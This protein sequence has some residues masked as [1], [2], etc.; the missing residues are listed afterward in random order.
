MEEEYPIPKCNVL[1]IV[2]IDEEK[3]PKQTI[4]P[5]KEIENNELREALERGLSE[6]DHDE[7]SVIKLRYGVCGSIQCNVYEIAE[8]LKISLP[9]VGKLEYTALQKLRS[10]E[11]LSDFL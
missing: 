7:A 1:S 6:L 5:E 8:H 4:T 9:K 3:L 2:D 10:K 11:G